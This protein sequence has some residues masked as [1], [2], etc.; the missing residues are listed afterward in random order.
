ML[1][2]FDNKR[3]VE[4]LEADK[5]ESKSMVSLCRYSR[6][7]YIYL[8]RI[9]YFGRTFRCQIC[10]KIGREIHH[11]DSNRKNNSID[12]LSILCFKCHELLHNKGEFH[13]N[14]SKTPNYIKNLIVRND[15]KTELISILN[16]SDFLS[17]NELSKKLNMS[18]SKIRRLIGET[19]NIEKVSSVIIGKN[20]KVDLKSPYYSL[21]ELK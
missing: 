17:I 5:E 1:K 8:Q 7:K 3:I 14:T 10:D 21:K 6:S 20:K 18:I 9:M 15:P 19:E 11:L 12:N 16:S 2:E 13:Y 4:I